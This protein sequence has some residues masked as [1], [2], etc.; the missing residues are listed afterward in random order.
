MT[1][2]IRC[3]EACSGTARASV[4]M[5]R[6]GAKKAMKPVKLKTVAFSAS[7]GA[8]AKLTFK[9][10]SSLAKT[11]ASVLNGRGTASLA[12]SVTARDDAGNSAP[13]NK[14]ITLIR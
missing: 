14:K 13:A 12:A 8:T 7:Q 9:L 2:T 11:M 4:T 6:R 3:D 1:L 10:T 5:K